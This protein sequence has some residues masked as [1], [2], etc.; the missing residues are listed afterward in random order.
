MRKID[1]KEA[2][3][4]FRARVILITSCLAIG[5]IVSY[6]V[7]FLAESLLNFS[8][9]G[10]PLSYYMGAQ[11]AVITFILLL[12]A[13]AIISDKLDAKFGLAKKTNQEMDTGNTLNQ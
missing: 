8:F 10:F 9:N 2:D 4:Y 7:V 1:K 3:A 11:G 12:F 13:N 6:L 5:F